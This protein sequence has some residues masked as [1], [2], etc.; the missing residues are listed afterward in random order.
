MTENSI[1]NHI[2]KQRK[3]R[4]YSIVKLSELSGVSNPYISQIENDKF[5]PSPEILKKLSTALDMPYIGL[6]VEA[7]YVENPITAEE[8]L[9]VL[10][11]AFP[12][13]A[14]SSLD[15]EE[16]LT[17]D[18]LVE[19]QKIKAE[20]L[21]KNAVNFNKKISLKEVLNSYSLIEVNG[22]TLTKDDKEKILKITETMFS[23]NND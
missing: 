6:L 23:N 7:G 15:L 13:L 14:N 12:E 10:N 1:G 4:G 19:L 16:T 22:K 21:E 2:K 11:F 18:K 5:K 20:K 17:N 3:A 8:L 9:S